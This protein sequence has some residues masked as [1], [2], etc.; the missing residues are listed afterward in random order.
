MPQITRAEYLSI[1]G[2]P[3]ATPAWEI[4]DLAPLWDAANVRGR[5]R[6]IPGAAGVIPYRR[7]NTVSVRSLPLVIF[8]S[9][10][11]D[12]NLATDGRI[13]LRENTDYLIANIV[14]P[15]DTAEGTRFAELVLPDG[16]TVSNDVH[17][18]GP[19]QFADL[20]PI[21]LRAILTLS[22]PDGLLT[23]GGS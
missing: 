14:N 3:L 21:S 12:G 13:Q 7:R 1:D 18:I 10:D 4:L 9:Y 5:D 17:V 15:P 6:L 20:G 23:V 2:I 11:Q 8:G 19:M 16:S 22:I